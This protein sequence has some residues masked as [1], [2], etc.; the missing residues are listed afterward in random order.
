MRNHIVAADLRAIFDFLEQILRVAR[1][2]IHEELLDACRFILML[3]AWLTR[4]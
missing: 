3:D 2:I 4:E 1:P